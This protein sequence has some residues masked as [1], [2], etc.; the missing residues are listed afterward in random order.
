MADEQRGAVASYF[1]V[2]KGHEADRVK[3]AMGF[4]GAL[5]PSLEAAVDIL[6]TT[7]EEVSVCLRLM[8]HPFLE[9]AACMLRTTREEVSAFAPCCE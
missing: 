2:Y 7:W 6:R 3:L 4:S 9:A 1:G 8:L 5:H